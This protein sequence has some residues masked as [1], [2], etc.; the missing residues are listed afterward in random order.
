MH[1]IY[2]ISILGNLMAMS[3]KSLKLTFVVVIAC[4][5]PPLARAGGANTPAL[6]SPE[7]E[8]ASALSELDV[9]KAQLEVGLQ[10]THRAG[11]GPQQ[12][13]AQGALEAGIKYFHHKEYLS[14]ARELTNFLNSTQVPNQ[15]QHLVAL[16]KLGQSYEK[17][18]K[19]RRAI[20][21]YLK[22]LSTFTTTKD[23]DFDE[24]VRV[25]R[26]VLVLTAE[27]GPDR[28]GDIGSLLSSL[29]SLDLP[30]HVRPEILYLTAKAAIKSGQES[31]A[32][33]W[34]EQ[35]S[36]E[37]KNGDLKCRT[38]YFQALI[39]V[40]RKNWDQATHLLADAIA[41]GG[42]SGDDS[43][44]LARLALA[45]IAVHNRKSQTAL[46]YY[47]AVAENSA[48]YRDALFESIYLHL[49]E[50]SYI[51]AQKMSAMFLAKFPDRE[52]AIQ[53]RSLLSYLD[54]KAGNS[55]GAK[56]GIESSTKTL[57]EL[58]RWLNARLVGKNSL[59]FYD[60]QELDGHS[61][62]FLTQSPFI[63]QGLK[64]YSALSEL[65]LQLSDIKSEIRN[66]L[67]TI[68]RTTTYTLRPQW[69]NRADQLSHTVDQAL[70]VGH[71]MIAAEKFLFGKNLTPI[72]AQNLAAS[73]ERRLALTSVRARMNRDRHRWAAYGNLLGLTQD[74]AKKYDRV[75]QTGAMLAAGKFLNAQ[76]PSKLKDAQNDEFRRL[77]NRCKKTREALA[78]ALDLIRIQ[79]VHEV[80][81]QS[82]HRI[83][84]KYMSQY[85]V[86]LD[87]ES[88]VLKSIRD[89]KLDSSGRLLA[90]DVN[91]VWEHWRYV[92]EEIYRQHDQLEKEIKL[93]LKTV[94][95]DIDI[96]E[97]KQ[98]ELEIKLQS[99]T[100]SLAA[101]LGDS[102]NLIYGHYSRSIGSRLS[103]QR[104][105]AGD[106]EWMS[107]EANKENERVDSK[108]I[109]L[110]RQILNDNLQSLYQ[111]VLW[112]WPE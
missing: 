98:Q 66:V 64:N 20:S 78:K 79:R 84:A 12:V 62:L 68:G 89:R 52:D 60:L 53:I 46:K 27:N 9:L 95:E 43:V 48:S 93:G 91:Q 24:M 111:G 34:L 49:S 2:R 30:K 26:R 67:Y 69:V 73:E 6:R 81:V 54:L 109:D 55:R 33:A 22:F 108:K 19:T 85:A 90:E 71:R 23:Q 97:A 32:A 70:E 4:A 86:A 3:T 83:T 11:I 21:T 107:F 63:S 105:W 25:V 7:E 65:T 112:K 75:L 36:N 87:E 56:E 40:S 100:A 72:Q 110:E 61:R 57:S 1:L 39:E 74:V 47:S 94:L 42:D 10:V 31:V 58:S 5:L 13:A 17:I 76:L 37:G 15:V 77:E 88:R 59:S 38:L 45:R 106:L 80:L 28:L 44:D 8:V 50:K 82:P 92:V 104:K 14:A 103:Q 99:L 101:R 18:G 51:E 29:A 41:A 96:A 102:A 35:A 16:D